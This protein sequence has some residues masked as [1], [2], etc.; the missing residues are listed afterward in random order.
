MPQVLPYVPSFG[1]RIGPQISEAFGNVA[2]G[3]ADRSNRRA[4]EKLITPQAAPAASVPLQG[5][6]NAAGVGANPNQ[7]QQ[8]VQG[9]PGQSQLE[10]I[11]SKPGG[12][13]LGEFQSIVNLAEKAQPGSGK[14]VGEFLTNKMKASD[15]EAT[16]IRKEERDLVSSGNK[17]YFDEAAKERK[18][19]PEKKIASE[20][21]IHAINSGQT[22]TFSKANI[23]S[24]LTNLGAPDEVRK[25]METPGSKE[26]KSASKTFL[27]ANMRDAFKGTTT[28]REINIAEQIGA[29]LGVNENANM[30]A[31]L[32]QQVKVNLSEE[33]LRL[34]DE[35]LEQGVSPSKIPAVVEKKMKS[36]ADKE[37]KDYFEAVETLGFK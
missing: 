28:G 34:T 30:A 32:F 29:E 27:A 13:S 20:A 26:F 15:K 18:S 3:F 22:G 25:A 35:L 16:Q 11:I 4:W 12:P 21:I 23:G 14:M 6:P 37:R 8:Q 9:Q 2:K 24:F 1:E 5:E 7:M 10:K 31:A 17:V 19:L 36:I 33:R